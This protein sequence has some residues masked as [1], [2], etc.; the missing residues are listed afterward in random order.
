MSASGRWRS[1]SS[2]SALAAEAEVILSERLQAGHPFVEAA[3]N[4]LA[5]FK[6]QL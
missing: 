2:A 3:H 4:A 1:S 6:E 5:K